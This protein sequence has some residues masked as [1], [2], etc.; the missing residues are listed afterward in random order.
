MVSACIAA[1]VLIFKP[2]VLDS[3][4]AVDNS[5]IA[6][7]VI[8]LLW[9][10]PE[11][12]GVRKFEFTPGDVPRFTIKNAIGCAVCWQSCVLTSGFS[13]DVLL[14]WLCSCLRAVWT[15]TA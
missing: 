1:P 8:V 7:Y 14:L 13:S 4:A 3:C 11:L 10:D 2:C 6:D 9:T 5:F 12:A 15:W